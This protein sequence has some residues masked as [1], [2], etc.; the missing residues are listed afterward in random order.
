VLHGEASEA[1]LAHAKEGS[2]DLIAAGT[3]GLATPHIHDMGSVSTSLL[4]GASCA[5]LVTPSAETS[6]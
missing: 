6:P 4:R 1:L 2:Y 5:V 3:A